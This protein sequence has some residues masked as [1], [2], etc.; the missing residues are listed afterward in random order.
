MS[1]GML[2]SKFSGCGMKGMALL[3]AML[4]EL[5]GDRAARCAGRGAMKADAPVRSAANEA[6]AVFMLLMVCVES[7]L[8]C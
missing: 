3:L 4:S 1:P 2:P 6:K 8:G 5:A 7:A